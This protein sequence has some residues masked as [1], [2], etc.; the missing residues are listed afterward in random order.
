MGS[1]YTLVWQH[2]A[3]EEVPVGYMLK[4]V[5]DEIKKVPVKLKGEMDIYES[6]RT[7]S[8]LRDQSTEEDRT[9]CVA[10]LGA[11]WRKNKAFK[12]LGSWRDEMW[13]VYGRDGE[14]LFSMERAAMGLFGCMR[15]GVHMTAYT[16]SPESTHG[17][18]IWVPKRAANKSTFPS[19]L[20]NTVAGGL[21]TGEDPLECM[22]RESDEEA[23][24][25]EDV[26]RT[27]AKQVGTVS[28]IFISDERSGGEPGYIYPECQWIFDLLLPADLTPSP[29]DGEVES[30]SLCTVEEI[31]ESLGLGLFKP[32]CAVVMLDFFVRHG[33]LTKEN[34]PD[35]DEIVRRSHRIMPFPGPHKAYE[36][37][38][39]S[40]LHQQLT[41][42]LKE[43][44]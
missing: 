36:Q 13:P 32:N 26:T 2:G 28:Y 16:S 10:G 23:S 27:H 30:F 38:G 12:L 9:V 5:F 8:I 1:I 25:P 34:E 6:R 31:K 37:R 14:L 3:G 41:L 7:I 33:I 43:Q 22:V 17:I 24:I 20:D 35:F 15:Y 11:H 21:M 4:R 39:A 19:M 42:N 40:E 18:K 29:K 44:F